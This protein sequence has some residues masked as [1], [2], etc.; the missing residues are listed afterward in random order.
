MALEL[1][2]KSKIY[3]KSQKV[4]I[5]DNSPE[6]AEF[7]GVVD[8]PKYLGEGKNSFKIRPVD[9][10]FLPNTKIEIEVLDSNEKPIY[11]EIPKYKEEDK[12]RLI[13]VWIY[14]LPENRNYN[15][16]NGTAQIIL[17]GTLPDG[18]LVRWSRKIDVNKSRKSVSNIVFNSTL[19][20]RVN[21]SS[22]IETFTNKKVSNS[23][24]TKTIANSEVYY[25][26]STFGDTTT[27]EYDA[28][29][30]FN[31]EMVGG[32]VYAVNIPTL[33]PRLGGGQPQ[34]TQFTGSITEVASS[35]I[36]RI[37]TPITAS[38][39]RSDGSIHTYEYSDGTLEVNIEYYSTGSDTST[40][41]QIAFA[42]FTLTN[43]K[44][45]VGRIDSINTLIKSQGLTN[46]DYDLIGNTK[47]EN[48][49][50]L[51]YKVP[52]PTE[53]LKDPKSLKL[54]FLNS[55]GEVSSTELVV[56]D[57]VF[58][59]GNVYIAGDQSLIS[60]S[61]HIG[62]AIGTGI[63]MA[64][65]SSGYL[66]SIGYNGFTSASLGK[67]AGGFLIW[68]GSGNLQLG[69]DQY[70]GVGMEMVSEGGSSS[71]YFTTH[72]GGQLKVITDEFFIGTDDTQFI[73]GSGGNI[74][75]SSSFFHL[76]PKD[77]EAVIGGFVITPNA[78]SSSNDLLILK[79]N[80]HITASAAMISGSDIQV[81]TPNF[82]IDASGNVSANR[83][84]LEDT[85]RA[86]SF[87]YTYTGIQDNFG[88]TN[89]ASYIG[90][91]SG[92]DGKLYSYLDLSGVE[93]K[94]DPTTTG[95]SFIRLSSAP[96]YPIGAIIHPFAYGETAGYS[97][98]NTGMQVT[99]ECATADI[100]FAF[101][102][103]PGANVG[104]GT[105]K[106]QFDY[107][108]SVV[109][110]DPKTSST[111]FRSYI[112]PVN[113]FYNQE[114]L[115]TSV[116][117]G[118]YTYNDTVWTVPASTTISFARGFFAWQV[119]YASRN[120]NMTIGNLLPFTDNTY[121]IGSLTKRFDDVYATNGTIQTSDVNQK[122][123]IHTSDLGL[124]FVNSLRPVS[125]KF[126]DVPAE[127]DDSGSVVS[128]K[129]GSRTHYG[130]IA[131]E[132]SSSLG[133]FDKTT[134]DFAG[135]TTGSMMGLRYTELISPMIKAIQELSDEVN[136][137]KIELSQSRG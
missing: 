116:T 20:P 91:Y 100:R 59:G 29:S 55:V 56:E 74:E 90:T 24:L 82:T 4:G 76:N 97:T 101:G 124:T 54:Q 7:F 47:V 95:A 121:D 129:T 9:G 5:E 14:D 75:I 57:I 102:G 30:N 104:S 86:D 63:E 44:P 87:T 48:T 113:G 81:Y 85:A 52:I 25:K 99:I 79:S 72:D 13:S 112:N 50:S 107:T 36:M 89:F 22:S 53:H 18:N 11:W 111:L 19:L 32:T 84:I 1:K 43:V 93:S 115:D 80:G 45:I 133:Q 37:N 31:A 137:L 88:N 98:G 34:P 71:F 96:T 106:Q 68:S 92:S 94:L 16:P 130:L 128:Y 64:G 123:E 38:D 41:N 65:H 26:K 10:A 119:L 69:D 51:S 42:N 3:L 120:N 15:T 33:F 70:P 134:L 28:L 40:Q 17:L 109:Y 105:G 126:K 8:F 77:S 6:S 66:K 136:Q 35:T 110:T 73:S 58:E 132:L 62:N 103:N 117:I 2:K 60:G 78:I 23:K 12:G 83:A 46:A 108:G 21:V 114:Y 27:L 61:F 127:I 118:A 122:T 125:Y 49:P 67:G 131:Q 39:N 135:I